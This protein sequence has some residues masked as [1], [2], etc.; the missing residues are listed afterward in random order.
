ME[1]RMNGS[2]ARSYRPSY[3]SAFYKQ[4]AAPPEAETE[5]PKQKLE[6][7]RQFSQQVKSKYVP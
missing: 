2:R 3:Q 7:M 6:K 4:I 5:N 1:K